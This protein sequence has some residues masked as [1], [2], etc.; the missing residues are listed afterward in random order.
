MYLS[1]S[2][3]PCSCD[4]QLLVNSGFGQLGRP[5]PANPPQLLPSL[6]SYITEQSLVFCQT[7]MSTELIDSVKSDMIIRGNP[8]D[9]GYSVTYTP[10][11]ETNKHPDWWNEKVKNHMIQHQEDPLPIPFEDPGKSSRV[12]ATRSTAAHRSV[13]IQSRRSP[14]CSSRRTRGTLRCVRSVSLLS[15]SVLNRFW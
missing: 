5:D 13:S 1:D 2:R 3:D 4:L 11:A 6:G 9:P 10:G 14:P 8:G 15:F 12:G 7:V